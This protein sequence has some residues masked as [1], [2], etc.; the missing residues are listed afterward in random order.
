MKMIRFPRNLLP[1]LAVLFLFVGSNVFA[2]PVPMPHF[3][4]SSVVDGKII[5]SN[6]FQGQ[7]LLITFF[8]TWCPPC[9]QE[10]SALKQ[11]QEELGPGGFSVVALSVDEGG[12]NIVAQ[13]V[14]QEKIN[15]PVMLAD[16][17][18]VKKFGGVVTIP[19]SFLV[20]RGGH[21]VKKYARYVSHTLLKRDI[22]AVLE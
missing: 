16:R 13:L 1:L 3:K 4:L 21:V 18:T 9:R 2:A 5:D 22:E 15:Y 14:K 19:T 6:S 20:N 10:I 12:P 11:L 7:V 8:A 17:A